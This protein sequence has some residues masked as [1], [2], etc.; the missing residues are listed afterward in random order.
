MEEKM[1]KQ[2]EMLKVTDLVVEYTSGKEV[3]HAVNGVSFSLNYGQTLGIVGETGAGKT[4]IAKS[5]LRILPV[6]PARIASGTIELEGEN[7]FEVPER[8]MGQIRGNKVSM[9][10]QDPMTAL[11]PILRIGEQIADG[12]RIH[13]KV[14]RAESERLA[15][16]ML[17]MVGIPQERF[18]EYPHQFSGGMKQ[19]VVIAIALACQP[20]LL[21]ADEPT[22]ALDVTIQ[23]QVM[24]MIKV[25][26]A[27]SN[28]A[29]ILITHDFGIV[30]ENCDFV[31]VIYA[32]QIVEYG[33]KRDIFK[34]CCHPYTLGLF[35]ALPS[36]NNDVTRLTPISGSPVDPVRLPEGCYFHPRCPYATEECRSAAVALTDVGNGHLCRC[37]HYQKVLETR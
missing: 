27:K 36:M 21:I 22:S 14:S 2:G 23:A 29:M 4:T 24:E 6:P 1:N 8:Q 32:G 28:T 16:G 12:I 26:Q 19:R 7:L 11:D 18:R 25:L 15:K 33:N 17:E 3:V 13:Q 31:A 30:A 35:K 20:D 5:I 34:N 10:F 37:R 9:I